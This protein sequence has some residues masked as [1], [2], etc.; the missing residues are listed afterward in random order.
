MFRDL[1]S[2]AGQTDG[3]D[4]RFNKLCA[5][6]GVQPSMIGSGQAKSALFGIATL[7]ARSMFRD[8]RSGAGQSIMSM[9]GTGK[10]ANVEKR[11][12]AWLLA[13]T[14]QVQTRFPDAVSSFS[15]VDCVWKIYDG[16]EV[17]DASGNDI[18][19]RRLLMSVWADEGSGYLQYILFWW[20]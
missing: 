8:L 20:A 16:V 13:L 3:F 2:G 4:A 15:T 11:L 12:H 17:K 14:Q 10:R 5:D 1:R 9:A 7:A 19:G 6:T 18:S